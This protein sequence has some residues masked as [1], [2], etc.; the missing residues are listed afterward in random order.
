[1]PLLCRLIEYETKQLHVSFWLRPPL[2]VLCWEG[3]EVSGAALKLCHS[4]KAHEAH[5]LGN[6]VAGSSLRIHSIKKNTP[7][8]LFFMFNLFQF[9]GLLLAG[10]TFVGSLC[11]VPFHSRL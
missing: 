7:Q 11:L 9:Y 1:M 4:R 5:V 2:Y 10:N 8:I 3:S 6:C